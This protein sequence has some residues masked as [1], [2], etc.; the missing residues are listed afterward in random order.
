M[1][2]FR[3]GLSAGQVDAHLR[4]ALKAYRAAEERS[5]LWF[6]EVL[7]RRLYRELGFSSI[8]QYAG[9][10]LGFSAGKTAQFLR[11]AEV[12]DQLPALR[13]SVASGEVPWTAAREVARVAT[14]KT[15]AAWLREARDSSR[16]ALERKIRASRSRARAAR[17]RNPAQG[18][19]A[20]VPTEESARSSGRLAAPSSG[21]ASKPTSPAMGSSDVTRDRDTSVMDDRG[22][23]VPV[24][25]SFRLSPLE[26]ARYEALIEALRKA[27]ERGSRNEV[28]LAALEALVV[29]RRA[30]T[31]TGT[32]EATGATDP[33]PPHSRRSGASDRPVVGPGAA[34]PA[35]MSGNSGEPLESGVSSGSAEPQPTPSAAGRY[36][37][38]TD[39][40]G[41]GRSGDGET[42]DR[43]T[44]DRGT[45]DRGA[46]EQQTAD[47][48]T[49]DRGTADR[50]AAERQTADGGTADRGTS[51]PTTAGREP[52]PPPVYQVFVRKCDDCG[53]GF[54]A[55]GRGER[56]L[57]PHRLEAILCDARLGRPG[58]RNRA[59]VPPSVRREVLARDG[60]RCR[61]PGCG[62]N[63]FIEVHH[64]R[65]RAAG[66][67]NRPE[68][69]VT[70]CSACHGVLHELGEMRA[71][72]LLA[73]ARERSG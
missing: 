24:D 28:L 36:P 72:A 23:D 71:R 4:G 48:G 38:K 25:L 44:A 17:R 7:R 63:R 30:S 6:G 45:A 68:N 15:E 49:A 1:I 20:L 22:M 47:G 66:G 18:G 62:R 9:E 67:L 8:H 2:E 19:L 65:P 54:V 42:A 59:A 70:L 58:E 12:L 39:R 26:Y 50:G 33:P 13:R 51:G 41:R 35:D 11:L 64:V 43:K 16:R 40:A 34:V 14:P 27:G 5:V 57:N 32:V 60:H 56:E 21:A 29:D 37:G 69:L 52:A 31:G 73:R 61:V 53:R 55:T 46:A 3:P 10:R